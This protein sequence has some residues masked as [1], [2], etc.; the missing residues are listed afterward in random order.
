M[1]HRNFPDGLEEEEYYVPAGSGR[2]SAIK[3]KLL[4]WKRV[5][6]IARKERGD[7]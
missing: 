3:K 2:E 7:P 4:E 1:T 5:R 6:D